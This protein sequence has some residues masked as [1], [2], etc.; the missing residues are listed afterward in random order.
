MN[1]T[2]KIL[3]EWIV[4]CNEPMITST[5]IG[6]FECTTNNVNNIDLTSILSGIQCL[7]LSFIPA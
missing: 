6:M 4:S 7:Y 2:C 5:E 3:S 1:V